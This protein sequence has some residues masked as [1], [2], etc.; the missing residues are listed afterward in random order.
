MLARALVSQVTSVVPAAPV[1]S[2]ACAPAS[3]SPLAAPSAVVTTTTVAPSTPPCGATPKS[4]V[5][6]DAAD[7]LWPKS[8]SPLPKARMPPSSP[9]P[10][11]RAVCT[12]C[13]RRAE[14]GRDCMRDCMLREAGWLARASGRRVTFT[15]ERLRPLH[16]CYRDSR[17]RLGN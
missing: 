14:S 9:A 7:T 13:S 3:P 15:D 12:L 11:A 17:T 16:C 6:E 4:R 10:A 2:A 8:G 5:G 1:K